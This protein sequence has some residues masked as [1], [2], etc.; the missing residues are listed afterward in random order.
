MSYG[1]QLYLPSGAPSFSSAE[2]A[3]GLLDVFEI[4]PTAS[5]SR[6]YP[7]AGALQFLVV[8]T[9]VEPQTTTFATIA[10]FNYTKITVTTS[11]TNKVV[12]WGE[13]VTIGTPKNILLYIFGV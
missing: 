10:S 9:L 13:G 3:I 7:G 4:T 6:T 11:G 12:S 2:M 5:G 1:F 8:Q